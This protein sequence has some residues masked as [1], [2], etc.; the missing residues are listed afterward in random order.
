M[1]HYKPT[2]QQSCSFGVHEKSILLPLLPATILAL[3]EPFLLQWFTQFALLSMFPLLIRDKLL[4]PY[5]ALYGIFIFVYY[6]PNGKPDTPKTRFSFHLTSF[7]IIF[8]LLLSFVLHVIYLTVNP[9]KKYPYLLEACGNNRQLHL[10]R[11]RIDTGVLFFLTIERELDLPYSGR[12]GNTSSSSLWYELSYLESKGRMKKGDRVW[13]I[14]LGSGFKCNS[15][16]W[17]CNRSVKTPVAGGPWEDC[18]DHYPVNI[19][20]VVKL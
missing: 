16:V 10:E 6:S 3:E 13:Q 18:I 12:F 15:A 2:M 7:L 20:E 8:V 11:S 17:R 9:P 5:I 1:Q 4:L 19:P 14:A